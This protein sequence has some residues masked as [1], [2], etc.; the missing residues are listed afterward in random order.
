[1]QIR[2][3]KKTPLILQL[4]KTGKL[5]LVAWIKATTSVVW[6]SSFCSGPEQVPLSCV[7]KPF[8]KPTVTA[9]DRVQVD[10]SAHVER[11]LENA[12]TPHL[13]PNTWEHARDWTKHLRWGCKQTPTPWSCT[14]PLSLLHRLPANSTSKKKSEDPG[15]GDLCPGGKGLKTRAS[16]SRSGL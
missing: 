6:F 2:V 10:H 9:D 3:Y 14:T 15:V 1:M 11:R 13:E 5:S 16:L 4:D 7:L 8:L 12:L